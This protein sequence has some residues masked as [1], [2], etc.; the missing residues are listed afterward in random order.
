[1]RHF[2]PLDHMQAINYPM[3]GRLPAMKESIVLK[4][5]FITGVLFLMI[6]VAEAGQSEMEK[7]AARMNDYTAYFKGISVMS[8]AE[9]DNRTIG[10]YMSILGDIAGHYADLISHIVSS[11][12]NFAIL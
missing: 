9:K 7:C 4:I 10:S 2:D 1:M 11:V 8:M 3:N 5:I 12:D 6:S